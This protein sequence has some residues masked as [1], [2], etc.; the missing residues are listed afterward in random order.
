MRVV[1]KDNAD[2]AQNQGTVVF[3]AGGNV[4][5]RWRDFQDF[6]EADQ[7]YF[8]Q[9]LPLEGLDF[10]TAGELT[11]E[12]EVPRRPSQ[13]EVRQQTGVTV[14][15]IPLLDDD[16][17]M[18]AIRSLRVRGYS[19]EEIGRVYDHVPVPTT[20]LRRRQ[21]ARKALDDQVRLLAGT[22]I[23]G[24]ALSHEGHD[25]DHRHLGRSNFQVVKSRIDALIRERVV[26]KDRQD[27]LQE[28]LDA[29]VAELP[30]IKAQ[31]EGE[32]FDG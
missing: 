15:E 8:D 20:K 22:I 9:L 2:S 13:V 27:F 28:E 19:L 14:Q 5:R 29:A 7:E 21:A 18:A 11:I 31:V 6:S 25:L 24:Q 23:N 32:F 3:H 30:S 1:D 17:A 12:P 4:A 16:V 10:T 26:D